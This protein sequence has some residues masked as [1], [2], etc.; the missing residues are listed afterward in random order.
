MTPKEIATRPSTFSIP[1]W[2]LNKAKFDRTNIKKTENPHLLA[3]SVKF[4]IHSDYPNHMICTDESVL[5]NTQSGA[6]VII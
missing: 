4:Q 1:I 6:T 5:D 2:E 3:A